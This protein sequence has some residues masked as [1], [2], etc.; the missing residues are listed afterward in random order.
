MDKNTQ[1]AMGL[2]ASSLGCGRRCQDESK[3][4]IQHGNLSIKPSKNAQ[5][6]PLP[7]TLQPSRR[8]SSSFKEPIASLV[9]DVHHLVRT[10]DTATISKFLM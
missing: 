6:H 8:R 5:K 7:A 3:Q 9:K 1:I 2:A 10:S 4:P